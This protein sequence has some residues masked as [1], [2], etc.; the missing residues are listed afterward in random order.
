MKMKFI[1]VNLYCPKLIHS[2]TFIFYIINMYIKTYA[3]TYSVQ[4]VFL[5]LSAGGCILIRFLRNHISL[6][7]GL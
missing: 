6:L 3:Q 7:P 1:H 2:F 5:F 4:K